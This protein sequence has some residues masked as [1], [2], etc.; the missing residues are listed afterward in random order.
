VI[1]E[2]DG[3]MFVGGAESCDEMILEGSNGPFGG[4]PTM[5]EWRHELKE[6]VGGLEVILEQLGG[7]I[8]KTMESGFVSVVGEIFLEDA[9]TA[10]DFRSRSIFER[11]CQDG[12][13]V[14]IVQYHD[15]FVAFE[16]GRREV[17]ALV[18]VDLTSVA[19][20][21]EDERIQVM[22]VL[23]VRDGQGSL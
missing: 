13:A 12:I 22:G 11:L 9:E 17:A 16:G 7:F 5:A 6:D 15:V 10:E 3:E 14:I 20:D 19:G 18:S 8:V 2:S 23:T 4:I 1:P 21:S